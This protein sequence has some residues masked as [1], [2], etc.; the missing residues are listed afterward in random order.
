MPLTADTG[1]FGYG[2]QWWVREVDGCT[3]YRAWGRRGQYIVVVPKLDLVI[4]V[5]SDTA[6][7]H[8]PTAIHYTPLFDIVACSCKKGSATGKNNT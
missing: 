4:V 2:Y 3:S 7:P 8:P 5:T 1:S 6:E